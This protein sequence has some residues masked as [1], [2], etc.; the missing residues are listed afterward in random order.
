MNQTLKAM[1]KESPVKV[2]LQGVWVARKDQLEMAVR[3]GLNLCL[4]PW[5][6]P[7]VLPSA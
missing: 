1:M 5:P 6:D 4:E 3:S 2:L 7:K